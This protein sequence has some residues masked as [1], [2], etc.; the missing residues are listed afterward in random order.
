[1]TPKT[2]LQ[3]LPVAAAHGRDN[4]RSQATHLILL[5]MPSIMHD[6]EADKDLEQEWLTFSKDNTR[7]SFEITRLYFNLYVDRNYDL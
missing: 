7:Q 3:I 4:L 1:M 6:F 5:K 2:A